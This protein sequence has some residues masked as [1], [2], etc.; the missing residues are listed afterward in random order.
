MKTIAVISQKGGAGKTTIAV[1]LAVCAEQHGHRVVLFDLDPQASA[2]KWGDHRGTQVPEV[3]SAQAARLPQLLVI[4]RS[5]GTGLAIIDTAPNSDSAALSA[6]KAADFI[7]IPCRPARFDLD[8]IG[9]TVDLA[10]LAGRPAAVVLNAVPPRGNL[11]EEA[12]AAIAAGNGMVSPICLYHRAAF[13]SAVIDGRTVQEFEPNGKAAAE[14]L[15]LYDWIS[16]QVGIPTGSPANRTTGSPS[17]H[18][19]GSMSNHQASKRI[20]HG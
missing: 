13:V 2:A 11:A 7:L 14:I 15:N 4:A 19:A 18:T 5:G 1:H 16:N 12:S 8:A 9:A 10:R 6:A 3:V 20:V 17:S